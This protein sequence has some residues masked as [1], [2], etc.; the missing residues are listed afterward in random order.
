MSAET[1]IEDEPVS[2]S[3]EDG[4][5]ER[6]G[7]AR[8]GG[9][10]FVRNDADKGARSRFPLL[11]AFKCAWDGIAYAVRTQRN[12][13]IHLV[14]AVVAVALGFAFGIDTASWAAVILCIAAVF[15]AECVNTAIESVVD[16]VSPGYHEL[17]RR[18]KD[19][20]AG[21]VLIFAAVAVVVACVVFIPPA[22]ALAFG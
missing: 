14:I 7:S 4:Q 17:A 1:A 6:D 15:A 3:G 20:A 19:C 5:A 11:C 12:M 13:K 9:A 10:G 21:A 2:A 8:C 16:L 18:A 22:W